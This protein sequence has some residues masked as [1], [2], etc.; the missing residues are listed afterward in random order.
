MEYT[1]PFDNPQ[2][3]FYLLK[4]ALGQISLWPENCA[5]PAGWRIVAEPRAHS[6]CVAWLEQQ[7]GALHP[8]VFA[9]GTIS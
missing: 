3:Q 2:G 1:H 4:N 9:R 5:L 8:A 7:G 6:D